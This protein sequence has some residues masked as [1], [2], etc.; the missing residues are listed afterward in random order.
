[1]RVLRGIVEVPSA[2]LEPIVVTNSRAP[3]RFRMDVVRLAHV[4]AAQ[5]CTIPVGEANDAPIGVR[6][7]RSLE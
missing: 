1:M 7:P 2:P 6:V 3:L 5:C 4:P